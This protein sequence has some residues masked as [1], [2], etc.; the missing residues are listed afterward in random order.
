[1][2]KT[3]VCDKCNKPVTNLQTHYYGTSDEY[4]FVASCH[5]E[6]DRCRVEADVFRKGWQI[7]EARAFREKPD[8][9]VKEAVNENKIKE[10]DDT[11]PFCRQIEAWSNRAEIAVTHI[12]CCL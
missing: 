2:F 7:V 1:M 6:M 10:Q 4:V 9:P 5:G 3:V 8:V 11:I 12:N